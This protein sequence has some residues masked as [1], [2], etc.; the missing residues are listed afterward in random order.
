M[1]QKYLGTSDQLLKTSPQQHI[2]NRREKRNGPKDLLKFPSNLGAH[3]TLMRFFEYTYG[4][5]K[6][7]IETPLAEVLLPLPKQIQ[8]SFKINVQGDEVGVIAK[9]IAQAAASGGNPLTAAGDLAALAGQGAKAAGSALADAIT[10][11]FSALKQ[12]AAAV[13]DAAGFL[14]SVGASK[15]A[16]DITNAIGAGRGTA[17]NPFATLVFKGVDLKVHQLEWVLSP[18]SEEESRELKKIIRTL[19]RMV[20]PTT[21]SAVGGMDTEITAINK[22]ILR[23]PAMVNIYL[24]GI[25]SNYYLRFKTSMISQLNIDYSPNGVAPLKGGKPSAIGITMTLNEAYIHTAAD[26]TEEELLAEESAERIASIDEDGAFTDSPVAPSEP[27]NTANTTFTNLIAEDEVAITK[28]N[29]DGST[30]T[31][32]VLKSELNAQGIT[33]EMI[34]SGGIPGD[35]TVSFLDGAADP[36]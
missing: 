31:V 3:A 12:G 23:Y 9:G 5:S 27:F 15:I 32:N 6:G 22:G 24:Q 33:D 30:S 16:P 17:V 26:N 11:D 7:A 36:L 1:A 4:G 35:S 8:D 20:L 19:Q 2:Q 34:E 14:A 28:T 25:D 10:G 21:D 18:E 29:A 13:G